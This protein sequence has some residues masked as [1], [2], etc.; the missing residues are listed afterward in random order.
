VKV[1][2]AAQTFAPQEEGG[3]E[4]SSR[5]AAQVLSEEHEV[6]VL[7]LGHNNDADAPVGTVSGD[8]SYRIFRARSRGPYLPG[9]R[10]PSV[11]RWQ[12]YRW[13]LLAVFG[14]AS[15]REIRDFLSRE[16]PDVIYANNVARLQPALAR[17]AAKAGIPVVQ[18]L[19]DY[20]YLCV[21]YSMYR[22]GANCAVPCRSCR[23]LTS[24]MAPRSAPP[25]IVVS[26]SDHVAERFSSLGKFDRSE[27]VTLANT[28]TPRSEFDDELKLKRR[29]RL[30]DDGP[31]NI[32]FLGALA[33]EKGVED[34]VRAFAEVDDGAARL[35]VAGRGPADFE[36]RLRRIASHS[37]V[38]FLGYV[39]SAEVYAQADVV[40]V[41]SLWHE[42]Q[43]RILVES[44]VYGIPVIAAARGGSTQVVNQWRTGWLYEPS[45]PEGLTKLLSRV[46]K[47]GRSAWWESRD[48]LFPGIGAFA[49]TA[50]DS[51]YYD[52]LMTILNR[53][54][55]DSRESAT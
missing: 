23:L 22:D 46:L 26:V 3:A 2:V 48:T 1:V 28:N 24:R 13:H 31:L 55:G 45:D 51:K 39:P 53:A 8:A 7:A 6:V 49:G 54:A 12:L 34:L 42:P 52:S 30:D 27:W 21:K 14:H 16:R 36:Q 44:A 50:E 17:E 9:P 38:D 11:K 43:S 40:V 35:L 5:M 29:A 32:A 15:R 18:H 19:R 47:M 41:P 4:I 10:R 20:A 33:R 25:A 37:R